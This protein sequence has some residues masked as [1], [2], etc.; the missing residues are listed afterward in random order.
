MTSLL[1]YASIVHDIGHAAWSHAGELFMKYRG[2]D[3]EHTTL[4]SRLVEGE[5]GLTQYF[6]EY[7]L[8]LVSEVLDDNEKKLVSKLVSGKAPI[9]TEMKSEEEVVREEKEKRFLGQ[10]LNSRALDFDRLEY[11][12]RD[13]FYTATSSSF[14]K[15]KDV[16]ENLKV[17]TIGD[18]RELIFGNRDFAESFV[19]TRELMY[20]GLY[21]NAEN[22]VSKE[23]LARAFN[24]CF[25]TSI[26]PHEIWF[27]TDQQLLSEL[28]SNEE[29]KKIA[30]MIRS[31]QIYDILYE[32]NFLGLPTQAINKLKGLT[33][34]GI[35]KVEEELAK[36]KL[37]P[38]Q[39][40]ICI[41]VSADPME[42]Y[43]WVA[44]PK[45]PE[46]LHRISPLISGMTEDY[47][48]SRSKVV[49][50]VD[51][52]MEGAAKQIAL[53]KFKDYF[54]IPS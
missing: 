33:K 11:L 44:T 47:R 24:L 12:I 50:A 23:M 17:E 45:G 22:L 9:F 52:G 7:A 1:V 10:I 51:P 34:P 41:A 28:Y 4:S 54:N 13:A 43:S 21:R 39:V 32:D 3:I 2:V 42:K 35:L 29:S 15:L 30:Q 27:N 18:A 26:D 49:F 38:S 48:D 25:D 40:L 20:S 14:F 36:P 19:I 8:P 6:A 31:R 46:P 16:F 53:S 37:Q 5:P